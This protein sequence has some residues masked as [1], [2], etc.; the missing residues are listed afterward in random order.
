MQENRISDQEFNQLARLLYQIAGISLSPAKKP[1]VVGRLTKRL[2]ATGAATFTEYLRQVTAG[3]EV[4]LRIMIDLLTTN[5]TSFF[6][7]PKHFDTLRQFIAQRSR[8]DPPLQ[9]W[10]AASS[11]GEEPYTIAM[12]VADALGLNIGWQILGTDIST[13]VLERA[14]SGHYAMERAQTIPQALLKRFCLKGVRQMEGT[15]LI[16]PELR[17]HVRFRH[18]NLIEPLPH[19]IGPFDVIFLRNVMIYFDTPTKQKIVNAMIPKLRSGGLFLVGHS[20]TLNGITEELLSERPST[21]R[22]P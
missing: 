7:E 16:A 10:S 9:I 20:E 8:T 12:V 21:Y 1:L 18:L 14:E 17:Q 22:K 5:E 6:R 15:F 2:N 13:R 3:D 19:D 11:S 4:E